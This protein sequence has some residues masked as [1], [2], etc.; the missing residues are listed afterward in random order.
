MPNLTNFWTVLEM[1]AIFKKKTTAVFLGSCYGN[2][3]MNIDTRKVPGEE[4]VYFPLTCHYF[5]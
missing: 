1:W 2:T 4:E 5:A 3:N